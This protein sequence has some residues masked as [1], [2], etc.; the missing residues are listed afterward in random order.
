MT[1]FEFKRNIR[2]SDSEMYIVWKG[3]RRIGKI[4]IHIQKYVEGLLILETNL[5]EGLLEI[6][7]SEIE[8]SIIS[9][10][11]PREDFILDVY[12]GEN[13]GFYSD[14]CP[15]EPEE[16]PVKQKH[17][18]EISKKL[19]SVVNRYQISKGQLNEFAVIEYFKEM[20][21]EA[22]KADVNFD[23]QKVDVIAK[24][25]NHTIYIQVKNGQIG[26]SEIKNII[27]SISG[28]EMSGEKRACIVADS[29]PIN[30]EILRAELEVEF[31]IS[32][33]FIHKYQIIEALPEFKRTIR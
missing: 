25:Q 2:T 32:I 10:L 17:L 6:L 3:E 12:Q 24:N 31:S 28:I 20:N 7:I 1:E 16:E 30:S 26:H 15:Y 27:R 23:K 5:E 14:Y 9:A 33:M 4:S 8:Y 21:Y 18:T 22:Y 13:V 19:N 29:L 11:E